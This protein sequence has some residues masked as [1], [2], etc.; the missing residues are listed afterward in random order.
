MLRSEDRLLIAG[1][2]ILYHPDGQVL[3]NMKTYLMGLDILYVLDNSEARDG[4]LEA[5]LRAEPKIKYCFWGENKGIAAALNHA[6]TLLPEGSLLLTMDQ[7][8]RFAPGDSLIY[9]DGV[10]R[11]MQ[12]QPEVAMCAAN[13]YDFGE[14][15]FT[16][17]GWE[18]VKAAITSGCVVR[19][20][21]AREIKGF[22]EALFIDE[23]DIDFSLRLV[24]AG[25]TIL[26]C[27]DV[28]MEH[29]I[30][31]SERRRFLW[32]R[33]VVHHHGAL[34]KYYIARNRVYMMKKH[35]ELFGAYLKLQVKSVLLILFYECDK[36]DKLSAIFRGVYDGI[37]GRMGK[38]D[39]VAGILP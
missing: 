9:L 37:R 25:Y 1:V 27:N 33:P 23:V 39:G 19:T 16:G 20:S 26:R 36:I 13:Y 11:L 14:K 34:R 22:D 31:Q 3:E 5:K 18:K 7:D 4:Q 8:S 35:S 21:Q 2:V 24:K 15:R 12:E 32:K 6:L 38:C 28:V 10:R 29:H 17:T 30:G